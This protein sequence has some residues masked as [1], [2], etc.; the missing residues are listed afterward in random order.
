MCHKYFEY[1]K[2][3]AEVYSLL[4]QWSRTAIE[5]PFSLVAEQECLCNSNVAKN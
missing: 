5:L 3:T 4:D 1:F 2:L